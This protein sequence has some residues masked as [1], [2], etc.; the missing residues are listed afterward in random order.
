[1]S[2]VRI[3]ERAGVSIATVSR[4]LNN[5]RR[6]QPEI[7]EQVR[8]AA[9]ELGLSP[10]A[11]GRGRSA[12]SPSKVKSIG[13]IAV[14]Q[15]YQGWLNVSVMNS[16]VA[17]IM[18]V[19]EAHE[20]AVHLAE[21]PDPTRLC[22]AV[23]RKAIDGALVFMPGNLDAAAAT[24][25]RKAVP[26][27]RVM[28]AQFGPSELDQVAPDNLAIGHLAGEYLLSRGWRRLAFV[29][30]APTWPLNQMRAGGL[31]ARGAEAGIVTRSFVLDASPAVRAVYGGDAQSYPTVE[32]LVDAL[33]AYGPAG[34]FVSRDADLIELSKQFV[35]RGVRP[36]EDLQ[37]IGCDNVPAH[38]AM[39]DPQPASIDLNAP[40][41][42]NR[43]VR[44]LIGRVRHP[45]EP[46]VRMLVAP[47]L[48]SPTTPPAPDRP[49]AS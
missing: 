47:R 17:E 29:S 40:E 7:A 14:G 33:I 26:V 23:Q 8:R 12:S 49:D 10:Q 39:F 13:L 35:R 16:I 24:T 37:I 36:G 1:M 30:L 48:A 25:L 38:L 18:R 2:V 42:A 45:E 31:I 4:V 34:V 46:P 3:A 28:G 6:V 43:A 15:G 11:R 21:M 19:A 44:R 41:I 20:F 5:S 9:A 22:S 27:V 32:S